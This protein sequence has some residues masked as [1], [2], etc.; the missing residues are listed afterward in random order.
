MVDPIHTYRIHVFCMTTDRGTIDRRRETRDIAMPTNVADVAQNENRITPVIGQ[1]AT[2]LVR[3]WLEKGYEDFRAQRGT[4]LAYGVVFAVLRGCV[5]SPIFARIEYD[6]HWTVFGDR[7][8]DNRLSIGFERGTMGV[9]RAPSSPA[10][11]WRPS[12]SYRHACRRQCHF[13]SSSHRL[14]VAVAAE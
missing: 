5:G 7:H 2:G 3:S 9:D 4:A 10:E 11:A 8:G 12:S 14:P 6:D 13:L 1:D